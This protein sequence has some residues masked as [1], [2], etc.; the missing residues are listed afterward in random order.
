MTNE[1]KPERTID[2]GGGTYIEGGDL[3]GRDQIQ[4]VDGPWRPGCRG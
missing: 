1:D 3:V 4:H 2:T